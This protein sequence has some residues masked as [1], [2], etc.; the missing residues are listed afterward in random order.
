MKLEQ[1]VTSL[2]LSKRLKELGV[3]QGSYF[4]WDMYDQ[5]DDGSPLY[6]IS[7]GSNFS[8]ES[9]F[10]AYTVA[11]LGEMLPASLENKKGLGI[12][13]S[14]I[15]DTF[16]DEKTG[17]WHFTYTSAYSQKVHNGFVADTEA[18]AR[19]LTL[20]YLIKNNLL[21]V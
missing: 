9:D 19:G 4:Y 15:I 13:H 11:E 16:K 10:S 5:E 18:E 6:K 1:Q 21:S 20:E 17:Y 8:E 14:Y 12:L 3:K 2:G 7:S